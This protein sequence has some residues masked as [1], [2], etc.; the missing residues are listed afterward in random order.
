[1]FVNGNLRPLLK[2]EIVVWRINA[3]NALAINTED[4]VYK[5]E[6]KK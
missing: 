4:R 6:T 2:I 5:K 1:M 3:H